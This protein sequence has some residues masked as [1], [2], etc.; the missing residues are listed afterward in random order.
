MK[1]ITCTGY[2]SSGSSAVNDLI[3]EYRNVASFSNFEFRFLHDLDGI[4]DLEFQLVECHNRL[5]SGHAIKRFLKLCKFNEGNF[6]S[7]RYSRYIEK[8]KFRTLTKEYIDSL[9]LFTT[10][11]WWFYDLYD[12]GET[13]YYI[14]QIINHLKTYFT[15]KRDSILHNEYM[16]SSHPTEYFFLERTQKYVSSFIREINKENKEYVFLDQIV[17]SSNIERILRYF[18][19]E[20]IVFVIDRDPR[21]IYFTQ[22][23]IL[24]HAPVPTE[25]VEKFCMWFKYTH[26]A[27]SGVPKDN[28]HIVKMNFEDLIYNYKEATHSIEKICGFKAEDHIDQYLKFNPKRSK[29]NTKVWRKYNSAQDL[30]DLLYIEKNLNEYLYDFDK[31]SD[32]ISFG[33]DVIDKNIF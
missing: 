12:K 1:I 23:Y 20:I 9:T 6:L 32:E 25:S 21:D 28:P 7:K 14:Y 22:K 29:H 11:S 33:I 2:H 3:A 27:G 10:K 17:P 30:S 16:Y 18:S 31:Y 19:D 5:N 4:S 15:G 24:K 26:N 13:I 8:T